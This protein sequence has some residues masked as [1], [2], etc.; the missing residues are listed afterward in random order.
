MIVGWQSARHAERDGH[1]PAALPHYDFTRNVAKNALRV[2]LLVHLPSRP[3]P[4]Y[5]CRNV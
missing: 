2:L 5:D 3:S 1:V 4:W